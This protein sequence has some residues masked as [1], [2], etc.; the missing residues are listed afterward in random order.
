[1]PA[2]DARIPLWPLPLLIALL[3]LVAAHAAYLLSIQAGH[4]PAC[5]PYLEGCVSISRAARHGVGNHLFRLMVMP[6]AVLHALVWLLAHRWLRGGHGM[7]VLGVVS[8]T[9]LAVYATFLGIEGET[10]RFLRRYGVVVYFGFGYLAQL[11]LMRRASRTDALPTRVITWM[12]WIAAAML[13]LGI[14][15]VVA[16]LV[17]ADASAK[18]RWENVFEWWLGLLMV[19][20]YAVLAIG[21]RRKR[22][23]A[24]LSSVD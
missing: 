4:V 1:M 8:A 13:G 21:W 7:V 6:C 20:W 12:S 10:Y 17:V 23:A 14:A 22:V 16:G 18:D 5:V 15:N 9:A 19:G 2:D 24:R 11:A 3:F